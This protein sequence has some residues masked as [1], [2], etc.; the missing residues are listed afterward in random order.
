MAG[1]G[2]WSLTRAALIILLLPRSEC[3]QG[4]ECCGGRG[5]TGRDTG[6]GRE[7]FP[8][9]AT[10]LLRFLKN[11]KR[12]KTVPR[13]WGSQAP[14]HRPLQANHEDGERTW[15]GQP[16]KG[17]AGPGLVC[18]SLPED[19]MEPLSPGQPSRTAEGSGWEPQGVSFHPE[20]RKP[21][22]RSLP[23]ETLS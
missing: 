11:P 16:G 15:A 3:G 18:K 13:M 2:T 7:L 20:I 22:Q 14:T 9:T 12:I 19:Q 21:R 17:R 1:P 8:Y 5:V 10:L 23:T 6:G 4:W